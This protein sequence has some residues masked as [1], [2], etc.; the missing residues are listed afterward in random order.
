MAR[1]IE[2]AHLCE[3]MAKSMREFGYPDVTVE[4]AGEILD[5]YVKG[6]RGSE[7]PHGI[8]GMMLESQIQE[9]EERGVDLAALA[10]D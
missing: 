8:V 2:R 4:M 6:T 7:L 3:A 10:D 9:L 1:K 5:A